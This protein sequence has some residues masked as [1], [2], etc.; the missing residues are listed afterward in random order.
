MTNEELKEA[1]MDGKAVEWRGMAY[2]HVTAI[3][4]RKSE[5]GMLIQVELMDRNN[6]SVVLA[7]PEEVMR[8]GNTED[9]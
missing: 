5:T 7:R 1:L 3:I 4:Y 8:L 6:N 9:A 2:S